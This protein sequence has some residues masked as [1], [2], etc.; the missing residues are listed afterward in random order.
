MTTTPAE[1][2]RQAAE[3]LR[4]EAASAHRASPSPWAVTAEHV[5]RCADGM[6]VADRS[7]TDHPAERANLPYIALMHPGVGL[8][9]AELLEAEAHVLDIISQQSPATTTEQLAAISH[10]HLVVAWQILGTRAARTRCTECGHLV[11]TEQTPCDAI[12]SATSI[13]LQRCPCTGQAALG[14]T[15]EPEEPE[16]AGTRQCGH[17][18]YHDAHEWADHPH[19]WCPGHSLTEETG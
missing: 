9:V 14:T 2:L 5:V 16:F 12:L 1:E 18:D 8:A 10:G 4:R 3:K 15:I 7:G 19:I 13:N 17:D 6:I 11:C